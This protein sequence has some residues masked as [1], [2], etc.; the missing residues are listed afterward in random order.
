MIAKFFFSRSKTFVKASAFTTALQV[1]SA[2]CAL[3]CFLVALP[4]CRPYKANADLL[5][6]CAQLLTVWIL[7]SSGSL[8]EHGDLGAETRESVETLSLVVLIS[9]L[10][11]LAAECLA[12]M[13]VERA[14]VRPAP[15]VPS[16]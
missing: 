15:A 16:S 1:A 12:A 10:L 7:I 13:V 5:L 3:V 9:T 6:Q 4:L 14:R 11:L 8:I 2:Q